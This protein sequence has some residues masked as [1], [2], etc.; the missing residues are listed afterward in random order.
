MSVSETLNQFQY[1]E[2]VQ[3]YLLHHNDGNTEMK[4]HEEQP[5]P[6]VGDQGVALAYQ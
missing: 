1:K 5:S 2:N 4:A 6:L 3:Q